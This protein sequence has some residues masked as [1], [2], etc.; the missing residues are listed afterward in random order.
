MGHFLHSGRGSEGKRRYRGG[1]E[2]MAEIQGV[3]HLLNG[4]GEGMMGEKPC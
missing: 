4:E 1:Y 2:T 3:F